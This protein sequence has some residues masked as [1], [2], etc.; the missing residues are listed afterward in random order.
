MNIHHDMTKGPVGRELVFFSLPLML[1]QVLQLLYGVADML[2]VSRFVGESGVAAVSNGNMAAFFVASLGMG[3]GSGG[4]VEAGRHAA[5]KSAQACREATDTLLFLSLL[6]ASVVGAGSFLLC[7]PAL[8]WLDVPGAI[9]EETLAYTRTV[10]LGTV[11]VFGMHT[12]CA[13]LRALGSGLAP[14]LITAFSAVL[15]MVLDL[16]LVGLCSLGTEGAA[17]ATVTAQGAAFFAALMLLRAERGGG[18]FCFVKLR[19]CAVVLRTSLPASAQMAAVN[20]SFLIMTAMLN[21]YGVA[22]AAA[23]GIGLKINTLAGMPCWGIGQAVTA[24]VAQNAGAGNAGRVKEVLWEGFRLSMAVTVCLVV[25][26]QVFAVPVMELFAPAESEVVKVGV[27][28]LRLC[29]S[30]NSVLYVAMYSFDSFALGVGR[31]DVA[32]GNA[33]L[34]AF[35]ARLFFAWL[36]ADILGMG[37]MGIYAGQAVSPLIPAVCGWVFYR[38]ETWRNAVERAAVKE[39]IAAMRKSGK[40]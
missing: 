3:F 38:R 2:V 18:L 17:W 15:N 21:R 29:C 1:A 30:V 25:P 13:V 27:E 11:F 8:A 34:E 36:G 23:S 16:V 9:M 32:L 39:R 40:A 5:D 28:Y 10:L 20:L 12:A 24:M 31:A 22:V 19:R 33:L 6:T 35:A 7:G 14:L 26:V 37:Y 4:A